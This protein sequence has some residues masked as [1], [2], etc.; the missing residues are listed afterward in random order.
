MS[1]DENWR[2]PATNGRSVPMSKTC[3]QRQIQLGTTSTPRSD[4]NSETYS[5]E[6]G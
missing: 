5:W 6:S 2:P 4:K 3:T 1:L